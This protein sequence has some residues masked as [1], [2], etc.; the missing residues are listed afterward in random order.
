MSSVPCINGFLYLINIFL[1]RWFEY[2]GVISLVEIFIALDEQKSKLYSLIA[3]N[4][5]SILLTSLKSSESCRAI[6][7]PVLKL[8]SLFSD[9][10]NPI[11]LLFLNLGSEINEAYM[12]KCIFFKCIQRLSENFIQK[13]PD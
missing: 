11:F 7:L 12:N 2:L 13:S 3:F 4:C 10:V 6:N 5:F 1:G 9:L 8:I